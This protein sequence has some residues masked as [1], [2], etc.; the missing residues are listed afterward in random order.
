MLQLKTDKPRGMLNPKA[1]EA[2]FQ[3]RRYEPAPDVAF[4]VQH[5]WIVRWDLRGQPPYLQENLPFPCVNLAIE[6]ERSGVFG[7]V[8]G[9]FSVLLREKGHVLGIKFRPG[10]FYPFVQSPVSAFTDAIFSLYEVFG[11]DDAAIEAAAL[12]T[13]DDACMVA[14]AEGFMRDRLPQQDETV[15]LVSQIVGCIADD[16]TIT[17]VDDLV[18]RTGLSRRTLQRLFQVYVGV[19]PK[20]VIMRYRLHE[21]AEQLAMQTMLHPDWSHLALELGYFDQAHFIKD[22]KMLVGWTPAEYVRRIQKGH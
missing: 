20:W 11:V 4:F 15:S 5:Y 13:E 3:L 21:A 12:A 6:Q 1:G 8:S 22:F 19:S 17:R 14:F 16:R 10:G 7:V 18:N 9:K 2:T